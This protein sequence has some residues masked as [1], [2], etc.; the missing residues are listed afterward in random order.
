MAASSGPDIVDSGLVLALDAADRNSYD[1]FENIITNSEFEYLQLSGSTVATANQPFVPYGR[2]TAV[3]FNNNGGAGDTYI[4][5]NFNTSLASGTKYIISVFS[6]SP[7]LVL[8]QGGLASGKFTQI[9]FGSITLSNGWYRHWVSYSATVNN[10]NIVPQV[11]VAQGINVT[12]SGWQV[13][14]GTEITDYYPT[15]GTTKT[16]GSTLIDLTGRGNTGTLTNGPT[17][18]SSNGGSIVFDGTD[19]YILVSSNASIPYTSSARTVSIWFYT[20]TTTWTDDANN[21]F[22]YGTSSTRSAFGIDMA[23]YPNMQFYAWSDD[24]TFATTYSQVGWKNICITYNGS[25][26][27]LIYE[28]G[29]FTRTKTLGGTLNTSTSDV[30]I[31]AINPSVVA[32]WYY[33][34]RI[35]TTQI[36]NR[37]LTATEIQQ[38]FNATRSRFGI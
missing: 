33:D 27:V 8:G 17:Y 22:F 19:D 35:A 37:A 21:L 29:V 15:T 18:N 9:S 38:N 32:G 20:N 26:T 31:G 6:N 4:Y 11:V 30:Y 5:R 13:E 16:R 12:L 3:N 14:T 1:K 34:G 2:N 7:T 10:P 28:N 24:L 36:Y 25:T 23:P